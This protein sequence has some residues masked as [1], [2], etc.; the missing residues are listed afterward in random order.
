MNKNIDCEPNAK[1]KRGPRRDGRTVRRNGTPVRSRG[2]APH[3]RGSGAVLHPEAARLA[4]CLA[5]SDAEAF[6]DPTEGGMVIVRH[7]KGGVSIGG[8]RFSLAIAQVL[9]SHDLAAWSAPG[10]GQGALRLTE[11]GRS[12]QRRR[13]APQPDPFRHQHGDLA[14]VTVETPEGPA[15]VRI[16]VEECPL[17]WLRRR[18]DRSGEPLIDAA[19]Y[20][21]GQRLRADIT[22]A[23]LLPGITARWDAQGGGP[24]SPAEATDR[25]IAAR[26]RLRHAFEALGAEFSDLLIDLCGFLKGLER[27]ERERRWPPRS[28]KVVVRLALSRLAAHYG[29]GAMAR[30]PAPGRGIRAWPAVVIDGGLA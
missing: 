22:I 15:H 19:G 18:K 30:G 5:R 21:A 10:A 27:I 23:G 24:S 6:I 1:G 14:T 26:Q 7:Q 8:G 3:V 13:T 25:M 29:L 17:D 4:S 20:E 12:H 2:A 28:A 11:A 16:D 9:V